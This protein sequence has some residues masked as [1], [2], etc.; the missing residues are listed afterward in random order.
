M[1][2]L[3][4]DEATVLADVV[5]S[6]VA[7]W[8]NCQANFSG[9]PEEALAAKVERHRP[10]YDIAVALPNYETRAERD[11]AP[12]PPPPPTNTE[13]YDRVIQRERAFKAFVLCI[14][15]GSIVPSANVSGATL[16]A[17]IIAKM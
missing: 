9:D 16:K 5:K 13:I 14:N 4:T 2:D 15:D 8:D 1:R 3:T 6:P 10:A 17:A 12:S 11:V 7:W